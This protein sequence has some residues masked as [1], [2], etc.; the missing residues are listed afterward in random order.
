MDL[1]CANADLDFLVP[2]LERYEMKV[3]QQH[4]EDWKQRRQSKRHELGISIRIKLSRK[5]NTRDNEGEEEIVANIVDISQNGLRLRTKMP[6]EFQ[7]K[8]TVVFPDQDGGEIQIVAEVRW[9]APCQDSRFWLA[10]CLLGEAVP[11]TFLD[12]LCLLYTSPSPRDQRG[13]RM[14]SSA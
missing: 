2:P 14:P 7:E 12:Q 8:V 6:L 1:I 9:V 11:E 4:S 3:K 13:S 10:G 5:V